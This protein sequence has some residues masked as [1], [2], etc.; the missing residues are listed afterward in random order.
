MERGRSIARGLDV[1]ALVNG[2]HAFH[3]RPDRAA[4]LAD[5]DVPVTIVRGSHDRIPKEV[6]RLVSTLQHGRYVE[7]PGAGHYVP[8]ERPHKLVS[9]VRE[10]IDGV[11]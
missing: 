11:V 2:V 10:A 9:I 5:L 7:V 4:L 8:I 1:E 3:T 6:E